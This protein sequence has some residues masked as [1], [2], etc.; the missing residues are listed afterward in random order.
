MQQALA[1]CDQ[2]VKPHLGCELGT[3]LLLEPRQN[4]AL[5][6]IIGA[7]ILQQAAR[8]LL[9]VELS[10][11][12]LVADVSQQLDH[13]LQRVLNGLVSQLLSSTLQSVD[14]VAEAVG[15]NNQDDRSLQWCKDQDKRLSVKSYPSVHKVGSTSASAGKDRQENYTSISNLGVPR[16][17]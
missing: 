4:A 1:E 11:Q 3:T 8:Q 13:L 9:P 16:S 17:G 12:V 14:A 5:V 15:G 6:L 7:A 10:K 2:Q